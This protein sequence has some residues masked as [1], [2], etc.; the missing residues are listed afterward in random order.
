MGI[1]GLTNWT[2]M[3]LFPKFTQLTTTRDF[4]CSVRLAQFTCFR[5]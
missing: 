3:I 5:T 1:K 2:N 4:T